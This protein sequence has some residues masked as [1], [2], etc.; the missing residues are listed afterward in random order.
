VRQ[1]P[2]GL[3]EQWNLDGVVVN[4]TSQRWFGLQVMPA[5]RWMAVGGNDLTVG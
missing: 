2:A 5:D 3:Y 4:D 1:R